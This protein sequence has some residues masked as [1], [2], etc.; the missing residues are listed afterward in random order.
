MNLKNWLQ[1]I[2]KA[3]RQDWLLRSARHH[4]RPVN[5][6][7]K[8]IHTNKHPIYNEVMEKT[9]QYTNFHIVRLDERPDGFCEKAIIRSLSS[10]SY[11]VT[12]NNE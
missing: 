3:E 9:K 4:Q 12:G 8:W 7:E 6:V 2:P 5:A 1:S 11:I 10:K